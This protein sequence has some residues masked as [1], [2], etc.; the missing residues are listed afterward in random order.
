M[1]VSWTRRV[2]G[3]FSNITSQLEGESFPQQVT[4][5]GATTSGGG[6]REREERGRRWDSNVM[7]WQ[8]H[9]NETYN[10]AKHLSAWCVFP[11]NV[12]VL[13]HKL[14]SAHFT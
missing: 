7:A 13:V 6:S 1:G 12:F 3:H 9:A 10:G 4:T 2:K 8:Y 11:I 5:S 14:C